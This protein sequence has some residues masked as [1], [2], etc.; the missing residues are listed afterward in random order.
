MTIGIIKVNS[1]RQESD[2][3][4]PTIDTSSP[5]PLRKHIHAT[6][7]LSRNNGASVHVDALSTDE[8]GVLAREEDIGWTQLGWL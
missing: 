7:Y 5:R 4:W 1:T 3:V 6:I 2:A 8:A